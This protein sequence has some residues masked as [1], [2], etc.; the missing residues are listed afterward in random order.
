MI[1]NAE[2]RSNTENKYFKKHYNVSRHNKDSHGISSSRL[3]NRSRSRSRSKER[4]GKY[5]I[6]DYFSRHVKKKQSF[7]RPKDNDN[8]YQQTIHSSISRPK[9][10]DRKHESGLIES[11]KLEE[12]K[13]ENISNIN[14]MDKNKNIEILTE[15]E[16]NKLGAR[17]I[18][19][20]I[21]GDNV[22]YYTTFMICSFYMNL[23]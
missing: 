9:T 12:T 11:L 22:C 7:Q 20:E 14:E 5:N 6:P 16:M 4:T 13:T 3:R 2:K 8:Y 18:K 19:A 15:A 21:M 1:I 23:F 10:S 17:I